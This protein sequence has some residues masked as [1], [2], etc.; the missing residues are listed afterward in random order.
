[1]RESIERAILSRDGK[2]A[3]IGCGYVGL[4]LA[5]YVVDAGFVTYAVDIDGEKLRSLSEGRSYI[6]EVSD[7][8]I[9][10]ALETGRFLPS[11]PDAVSDADVIL[12]CVPTPLDE[13]K[14]PDL[15][16]IVETSGSIAERMHPSL[17]V[18][19]STTYPTTTEEV[20]KPILDGSGLECGRDY[21]L[22]Y[23]PH[24]YDPGNREWSF[25]RIPKVVGGVDD[26]SGRLATLFYEQ[27]VDE[28][29]RVSS[30]RCAE[31]VKMLENIF[32]AVN[33]ALVNETKVVFERLGIDPFEVVEAAATKPFGFMPFYPGPGYGGHCIPIDP[34][35]FVWKAKEVGTDARFIE[36]AGEVN[37]RTI[38]RVFLRFIEAAH[39]KGIPL[40]GA[41]VLI[42]GVSYKRDVGDTRESPAFPIM[43]R[44]RSLGAE[45]VYSDPYVPRI[46]RLRHYA[47]FAGMTSVALEKAVE[48]ASAALIITDHSNFNYS[49]LVEKVP[50]VV[51]TRGVL[52]RLGLSSSESVFT[53]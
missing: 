3:V 20:V 28:V 24:R 6:T 17:V 16:A 26:A 37:R 52:R 34:F 10:A 45:L 51:D 7:E 38:E 32:R 27:V 30:A 12:I 43:R 33:I 4:P 46:G 47:E 48:D 36:L 8:D 15:S 53:A 42:V 40:R 18:L 1:M 49:L 50:L 22:A 41:K 9:R 23:S 44:L 35:Y 21:F 13:H 2:V 31:G 25:K 14:V 11:G 19:E 29:V 5:L 39:T